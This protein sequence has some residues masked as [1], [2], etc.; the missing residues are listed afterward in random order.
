MSVSCYTHRV[1]PVSSLTKVDEQAAGEYLC[2]VRDRE[3]RTFQDS[4]SLT[5]ER[6]YNALVRGASVKYHVMR[7]TL[8]EGQGF[9]NVFDEDK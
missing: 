7:V 5:L 4:I 9:S 8:S 2:S 3:G 6:E 1:C